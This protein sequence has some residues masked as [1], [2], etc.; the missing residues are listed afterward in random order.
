MPSLTPRKASTPLAPTSSL[1]VCEARSSVR[2]KL[3][4]PS[5]EMKPV[6]I[7]VIWP[8]TL[9][10]FCVPVAVKSSV[11]APPGVL[12]TRGMPMPSVT[13]VPVLL[14]FTSRPLLPNVRPG[15]P[16]S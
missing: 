10:T 16:T 2:V 15:T 9:V 4:S 5:S 14:T 7:S 8:S 12:M 6:M 3:K 13:L 11:T 1:V